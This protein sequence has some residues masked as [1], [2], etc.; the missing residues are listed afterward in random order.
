MNTICVKYRR[1]A[2]RFPEP[3]VAQIEDLLL[4]DT[5]ASTTWLD[6][7]AVIADTAS[8]CTR[9]R[10]WWFVLRHGDVGI[11]A[12]LQ[13]VFGFVQEGQPVVNDVFA[14]DADEVLSDFRAQIHRVATETTL[15]PD[16]VRAMTARDF[17]GVAQS[18]Q[19]VRK[20]RAEFEA[21]LHD[22]KLK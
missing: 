4:L 16:T 12:I 17:Y 6:K 11:V 20:Q 18:V 15:T 2:F 19:A 3:T 14:P 22:K 10:L 5:V 1:S 9:F 21:A 13:A 8:R 7:L